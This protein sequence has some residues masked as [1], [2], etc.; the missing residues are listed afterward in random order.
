MG[1]DD[2]KTINL[3]FNLLVG[4]SLFIQENGK[5]ERIQNKQFE[6]YKH[7]KGG[8]KHNKKPILEIWEIGKEIKLSNELVSAAKSCGRLDEQ[9]KWKLSKRFTVRGHWRDQPCGPGKIDRKKTWIQP[10]WKGSG[11][12]LAHIYTAK[13]G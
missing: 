7:K 2:S 3:C 11:V 1:E 4:L 12:K 8:F 6:K 10:Y 9:P 5:G 13:D